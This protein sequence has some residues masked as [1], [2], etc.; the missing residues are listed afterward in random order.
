[1]I[2]V[3]NIYSAVV[4]L[5]MSENAETLN[6]LHRSDFRKHWDFLRHREAVC[7]E[8]KGTDSRVN[9]NSIYIF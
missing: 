1:M 6:I 8:V 9:L 2:Y 3:A 7:M 4:V 5:T